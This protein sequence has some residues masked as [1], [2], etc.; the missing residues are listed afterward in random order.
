VATVFVTSCNVV[1][2]IL[3]IHTTFQSAIVI[4]EKK[5]EPLPTLP[6]IICADDC[7]DDIQSYL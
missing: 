2:L 3:P 5:A 4:V 7:I 1:F 6:L